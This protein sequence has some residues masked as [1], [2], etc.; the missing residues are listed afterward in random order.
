MCKQ[1]S[2]EIVNQIMKQINEKDYDNRDAEDFKVVVDNVKYGFKI[3]EDTGWEDDNKYDYRTI[4]FQLVERDEKY[5]TINEFDA[6]FEQ[7][8]SRTGSYYTDW[9]Y[10]YDE[11]TRLKRVEK[12]IPEQVIPEHT[13]IV[14]ERY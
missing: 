5:K 3:I 4:T 13:V 10:G 9:Y 1:I 14:W 8:S 6:Y 11:I 2:D 7:S 12:V